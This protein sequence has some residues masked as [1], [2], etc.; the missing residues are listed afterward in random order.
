L[1]VGIGTLV[2]MLAVAKTLGRVNVTL[3]E[4]DKQISALGT[5]VGETLNHVESIAGT[6]DE[7][8][9]RLGKAI[10][11]IEGAAGTVSSTTTLTK[12]AIAPAIV[13]L[14]ATLTGLSAGLRKLITGKDSTGPT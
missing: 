12:D 2:G 5:P 8:L 7:T 4:V 3:D 1:L 10:A 9:A 11:S 14:G 6:A 13:N